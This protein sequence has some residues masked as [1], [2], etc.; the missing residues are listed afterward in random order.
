MNIERR[1]LVKSMPR[2][3]RILSSSTESL[4]EH[5]ETVFPCCTHSLAF[6]KC[7]IQIQPFHLCQNSSLVVRMVFMSFAVYA[8]PSVPEDGDDSDDEDE[9]EMGGVT[10][11][12]TCPITLTPLVDPMTS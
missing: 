11:S 5:V 4:Y 9:L 8:H 7:K 6:R 10:Q 3:K 12:Y 2:A 1:L